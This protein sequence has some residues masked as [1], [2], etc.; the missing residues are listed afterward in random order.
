MSGGL[1]PTEGT[2]LFRNA[3]ESIGVVLPPAFFDIVTEWGDRNPNP[4]PNDL[5]GIISTSASTMV[6]LLECSIK[7]AS[8][9]SRRM[10]FERDIVTLIHAL[11]ASINQNEKA[12]NIME[13]A[14]RRVFHLHAHE[15]GYAELQCIGS[16][17]SILC[18]D[19]T[20][21]VKSIAGFQLWDYFSTGYITRDNM[22]EYLR[23]VFM[24]RYDTQPFLKTKIGVNFTKLAI[25]TTDAAFSRFGLSDKITF[26]DF[27]GWFRNT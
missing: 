4:D 8:Q 3:V 5:N 27:R 18:N 23:S 14:I 19:G 10:V 1:L 24:I 12:A 7:S 25:I 9:Y 2:V 16:S 22:V 20:T 26:T 13:K 21:S 15:K 6:S 17:L 11:K